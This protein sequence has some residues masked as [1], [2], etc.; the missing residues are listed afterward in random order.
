VTQL[1]DDAVNALVDAAREGERDGA[2]AAAAP[3]ESV[4]R[5][6][7]TIRVVDFRRTV[8]FKAEHQERLKRAAETFCRVAATRLTSELRAVADL[9]LIDSEQGMWSRVHADL[10][11]GATCATIATGADRPPLLLAVE[12]PFVLEAVDRLLGSDGRADVVERSLTEVDK[13]IAT[14]FLTTLA[15]CLASAWKEMCGEDLALQRV[16]GLEQAADVAAIEEPTL[17][18]NLEAKLDQVLTAMT[19]LIPFNAIGALLARMS[20]VAPPDPAASTAVA[21]SLGGIGIEL[22]AE[23]GSVMLTTDEVLHLA[24]GDVVT[25]ETPA[26]G[27]VVLYADQVPLVAARPGRN[28]RRRAVQVDSTLGEPPAC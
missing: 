22:R 17:V 7:R 10:A 16:I 14:R 1:S 20:N 15:N 28:G 26:A 4:R 8:K 27:G 18:L 12:Q 24:P 5:R 6:P 25:L 9:Q 2:P 19:L 11:K 23:L 21:T 13:I 3:H